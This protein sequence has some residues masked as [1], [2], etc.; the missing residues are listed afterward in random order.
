MWAKG[1]PPRNQKNETKCVE[2]KTNTEGGRQS[3]SLV[4]PR[5]PTPP[6]PP[7]WVSCTSLDLCHLPLPSCSI[8]LPHTDH[9]GSQ[10]LRIGRFT[11]VHRFGETVW[12]GGQRV[13]CTRSTRSLGDSGRVRNKLYLFSASAEWKSQL[14]GA[15]MLG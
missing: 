1:H 10:V 4:L 8:S 5:A 14:R 3:S 2:R 7:Y 13:L 15:S 12:T 11:K 9:P 6:P